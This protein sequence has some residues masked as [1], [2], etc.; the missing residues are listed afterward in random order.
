[1][2]SRGKLIVEAHMTNPPTPI[3]LHVVVGGH[4]VAV[5]TIEDAEHAVEQYRAMKKLKD[6]EK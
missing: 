4:T 5:L 3:G 2:F 1:M 6:K